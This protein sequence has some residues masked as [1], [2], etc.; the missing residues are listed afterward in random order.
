[1]IDMIFNLYKVKYVMMDQWFT[2]LQNKDVT[3]YIDLE[4]ILNKLCASNIKKY[5]ISNKEAHEIEFISSV[6]NL[7]SHYKWYFTKKKINAKIVLYIQHPFKLTK[8]YNRLYVDDYK[9]AYEYRYNKNPEHMGISK[10]ID[11][12]IPYTQTILEYIENVYLIKS[13]EIESSMIPYIISKEERFNNT[14]G[15]VVSTDK[16][17]LQ[18]LS[19]GFDIII[20]KRD[21]S[22]VIQGNG[23]KFVFEENH[24]LAPLNN[25]SYNHVSFILSMIGS[26][27]K[28]INSI[29]GIGLKSACKMI[30]KAIELKIISNNTDN[31]SLLL[32][33]TKEEIKDNIIKNHYCI[34]L[35][36]QYSILNTSDFFKINNQI[37]DKFDNE[38]LKMI[39]DE[40]FTK[41]PLNIME[42]TA[43]PYTS[44]ARV[45]F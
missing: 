31:L 17:S 35:D 30:N 3:V 28:S 24:F 38:S 18:Y 23:D 25:V 6:I 34:S 10:V 36:A 14:H 16:Y 4:P 11:D 41:Y 9:H 33:L 5:L 27:S 15:I 44:S 22:T 29:K 13:N 40:V 2:N 21:E 8:M 26:S 19:K 12:A 39:N 20:P 45:K 43:K 42:I 1:M 37:K 7:A 32:N